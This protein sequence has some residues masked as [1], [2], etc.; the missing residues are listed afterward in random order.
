MT[1]H[2][3]SAFR[4]SVVAWAL[5]AGTLTTRFLVGCGDAA[6][7]SVFVGGAPDAGDE[8]SFDLT[9]PLSDGGPDPAPTGPISLKAGP[10]LV[11]PACGPSTARQGCEPPESTYP[12][13]AT[14]MVTRASDGGC[15]Q[16]IHAEA[17][18]GGA[19]GCAVGST[20]ECYGPL[21]LGTEY[22][23]TFGHSTAGGTVTATFT[24]RYGGN[25]GVPETVAIRGCFAE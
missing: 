14:I 5:V 16:A 25:G 20:T 10:P 21:E 8:A 6:Q 7:S 11:A 2:P 18:D 17:R 24:L 19:F 3:R 1:R 9:P 4:L 22:P 12:L 15:R 23:F 13:P